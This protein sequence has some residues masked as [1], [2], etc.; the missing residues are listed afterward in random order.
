M[1][2]TTLPDRFVLENADG[3]LVKQ[4][5]HPNPG[6]RSYGWRPLGFPSVDIAVQFMIAHTYGGLRIRSMKADGLDDLP[7]MSA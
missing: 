5:P 4:N 3:M 7:P 1:R 6:T 2:L